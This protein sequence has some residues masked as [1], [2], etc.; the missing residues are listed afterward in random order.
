M[1]INSATEQGVNLISGHIGG[2][3]QPRVQS[4]K[5]EEYLIGAQYIPKFQS[6]FNFWQR[7][8]HKIYIFWDAMNVRITNVH[9]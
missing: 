2:R 6:G 7:S 3:A 4:I 8:Q 1:L 9:L 5:C